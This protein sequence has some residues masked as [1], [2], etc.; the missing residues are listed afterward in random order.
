MQNTNFSHFSGG[1]CLF[2]ENTQQQRRH[3]SDPTASNNSL[4]PLDPPSPLHLT[5]PLLDP[6]VLPHYLTYMCHL[7]VCVWGGRQ[8]GRVK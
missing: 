1:C 6:S 8:M 7:I 3:Q 5:L 2:K 4:P